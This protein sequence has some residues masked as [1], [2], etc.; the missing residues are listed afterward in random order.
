M[1][2]AVL[3]KSTNSCIPKPLYIYKKKKK[4]NKPWRTEVLKN[5]WKKTL[6]NLLVKNIFMKI[7]KKNTKKGLSMT[8]QHWT[9]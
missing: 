6:I 1:C 4:K 3:L 5:L 7:I 8:L 9:C 2:T